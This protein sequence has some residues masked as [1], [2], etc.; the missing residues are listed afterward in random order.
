[1]ILGGGSVF[2]AVMPVL[3]LALD[4]RMLMRLTFATS[5]GVMTFALLW[6]AVGR[7]CLRASTTLPSAST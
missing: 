4:V 6:I 5:S 3:R 2:K 7:R 1:M